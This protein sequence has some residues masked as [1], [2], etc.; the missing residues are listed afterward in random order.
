[1]S[2]DAEYRKHK[3]IWRHDNSELLLIVDKSVDLGNKH[4]CNKIP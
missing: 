4:N 3:L 2:S 1:M